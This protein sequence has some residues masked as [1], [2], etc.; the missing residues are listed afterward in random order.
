MRW[1][2]RS[3]VV[4]GALV[5]ATSLLA[6][7]VLAAD[8]APSHD[9]G[10]PSSAHALQVTVRRPGRPPASDISVTAPAKV[11]RIASLIDGLD[12]LQPGALDCTGKADDPIVTFTFRA[13]PGTRVLARARQ[14]IES[15]PRG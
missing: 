13:A 15:S 14:I 8:A 5:L 10:I 1:L 9:A 6:R 11:K 2:R 3:I 12:T 4:L 7:V